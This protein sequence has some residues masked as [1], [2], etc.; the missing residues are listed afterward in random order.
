MN[1]CLQAFLLV[2]AYHNFSIFIEFRVHGNT[3][4]AVGVS[5]RNTLPM[6]MTSM[7]FPMFSFSSFRVS[8]FK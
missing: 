5:F 4:C 8:V 3:S 7:I 2:C 1:A 6:S